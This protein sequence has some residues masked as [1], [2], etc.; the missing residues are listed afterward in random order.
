MEV[1]KT[2]SFSDLTYAEMH[3]IDGGGIGILGAVLICA[4]CFVAGAIIVAGVCFLVN[5]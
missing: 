5:G 4:G 1:I 3:E 2:S